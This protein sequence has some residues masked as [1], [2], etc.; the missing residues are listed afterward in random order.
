MTKRIAI[1]ARTSTADDQTTENQIRE[2]Q[3][4]A[5]R[6]GWIIV[7]V[8]DDNGVSGSVPRE[9]RP[10][11]KALLRAVARREIDMVAAWAVDRRQPSLNQF[12][13][14]VSGIVQEDVDKPHARIHRLDR[15]QQQDRAQG[16]HRQHIFHDGLAGLKIDCT[17]DVE[18]VP[19]VAMFH[20]DRQN[21][22]SRQDQCDCGC[23]T[24]V[25]A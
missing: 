1:Y 8:F 11:M 16:I 20:R 23:I 25:A 18:A 15:H 13:V 6:H 10:A 14:M 22:E 7:R 21:R 17:M 12:R 9:Q 3:H 24:L 19:S 2:L 4:V 5:N